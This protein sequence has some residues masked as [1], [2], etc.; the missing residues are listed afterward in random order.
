MRIK[1]FED[2]DTTLLEFSSQPPVET[3]EV[4]ENI[5]IDL[6]EKGRVVSI[7]LEH[8]GQLA[9]MQELIFQRI[10]ESLVPA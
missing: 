5:Y 9:N 1:Y 4:S 2:T 10:P 6:D 7:T 8:V 3:R